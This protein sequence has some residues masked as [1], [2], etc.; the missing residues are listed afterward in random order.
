MT[1]RTSK[2]LTVSTF[3]QKTEQ[4][5]SPHSAWLFWSAIVIYAVLSLLTFNLRISEGGDDSSYIIRAHNF[6]T[7]GKFPSYQGPLYPLVLSIFIALAGVKVWMLKI[8]SWIFLSSGLL[9]FYKSFKDRISHIALWGTIFVLVINH[10]LLYFGSQTYSEAFFM[11]VQGG[12]FLVLFRVMKHN[13]T[14]FGWKNDLFLGL[15]VLTLSVTRTVGFAAL[16]ALLLFLLLRKQYKDAAWTS[17]FFIVSISLF[18]AIKYFIWNAHPFDGDQAVSLL[19]KHPYD[20]SQGK[21]TL[22]GFIN[23]IIGNSNLY[24]SKHFLIMTGFKSAQSLA[25][26]PF[27]TIILYLFFFLGLSFFSKKKNSFMLFAGIYLIFMLG[28]TFFSLQTLWDQ[29]RLII[30]FFPL[31]VIFLSETLVSY[32]EKSKIKW[33]SKVPV[34][35]LVLSVLL[36]FSQTIKHNDFKA[37]WKN[38]A[39]DRYYGYTPDWQ[40]YLRMAEYIRRKLPSDSYVACR[41]PSMASLCANGK[42]FYGIYRFQSENPDTLLTRLHDAGVT[43]VMLASL[44]KD[45]RLNTGRVIN[46]IHRYVSIINEKYPKTFALCKQTGK[47]EPAWLFEVNYNFERDM[48]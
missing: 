27:W 20:F 32:T 18:F 19:N 15:L 45:P 28:A 29:E 4:T 10:H 14:C 34:F 21:E 36:S 12:F 16:P 3:F 1:E 41:K 5:L 13:Q 33:F 35:I 40:N 47:S 22:G 9:F 42:K 46:T 7:E 48:K 43:H 17:L 37:I 11:M 44:R 24:L 6:L 39:G 8:T 2:E 31:M 38:L 25:K 23:R 26:Q 30:P